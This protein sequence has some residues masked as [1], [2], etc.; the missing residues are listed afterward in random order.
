MGMIG[1]D[2]HRYFDGS[3]PHSRRLG[4]FSGY[5]RCVGAQGLHAFPH[6]CFLACTSKRS[7]RGDLDNQSWAMSAI[8]GTGLW[9]IR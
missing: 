4:V 3:R 5:S 9:R 6:S 7:P 1:D 8:G 2:S